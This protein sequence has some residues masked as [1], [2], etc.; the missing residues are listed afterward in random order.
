MVY[1]SKTV[2]VEWAPLGIRINCVAPGCCETTAFGRYPASG[3]ATFA[4]SNPMLRAGDEWD[5]A[6]AIAYLSAPSGKFV[7]GEVVTVDG[8]QQLWGDMWAFGRPSWFELDYAG[9]ERED[10]R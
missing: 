5:V 3:A 10:G 2:A 7:T 9:A 6:E 8:G 1:L 4:Q